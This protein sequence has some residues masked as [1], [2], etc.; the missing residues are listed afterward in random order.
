MKKRDFKT[1]KEII[2][3][4][5]INKLF[6]SS[7][8]NFFFIYGIFWCNINKKIQCQHCLLKKILILSPSQMIEKNYL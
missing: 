1:R 8:G 6:G 2:K 3:V 7:D 4:K 5:K